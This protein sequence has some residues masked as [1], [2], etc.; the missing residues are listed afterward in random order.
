MSGPFTRRLLAEAL[1][2]ALLLATVVGSGIMAVQ[3]ADGNMSLAL[4][5]NALATGAMLVVLIT[6]FGAISGAHF[7]PAVSLVMALDRRLAWSLVLPYLAAQLGGAILGTW[8]AHA[9]F[10]LPLLQVSA[11]I[12]TGPGQWLGEATA[13]SGLVLT[14]LG[15]ITQAPKATPAAVG[16][17]IFAA[18]WFTSSTSFANPAV[19]IARALSD[20]FAGIAPADAPAFIASQ[21]VGALLGLAAGRLLWAGVTSTGVLRPSAAPPPPA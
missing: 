1:G 11:T 8:L 20:T 6:L 17:Y 15:C 3:L 7:N 21:I 2:T 4:L 18:Y 10:D 16:L 12:R 19:T 14:I 5:C 13:T 9:M